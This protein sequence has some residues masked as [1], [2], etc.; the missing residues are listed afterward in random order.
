MNRVYG[1]IRTVSLPAEPVSQSAGYRSARHAGGSVAG[2]PRTHRRSVYDSRNLS[3]APA[4]SLRDRLRRPLQNPVCR[5]VRQLSGSGEGPRQGRALS[6]R[7]RDLGDG[8]QDQQLTATVTATAAATIC[9]QRPATAH[10]ARSVRANWDMSGLKSRRSVPLLCC[11]RRGL[12]LKDGPGSA[13]AA[14]VSVWL[15][16]GFI[17]SPSAR[18]GPSRLGPAG[19]G[20]SDGGVLHLHPRGQAR[21]PEGGRRREDEPPGEGWRVRANTGDDEH[22]GDEHLETGP[23][24]GSAPVPPCVWPR[25]PAFDPLRP[26]RTRQDLPCTSAGA[27]LTP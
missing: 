13:R 17:L 4:A 2:L 10:N 14:T 25:R 7:R 20:R 26:T 23:R 19:E 12:R 21:Y 5:Q 1:R 15:R 18:T 27:P 9:H 22:Q 16:W 3:R 24:G 11:L 8:D 6:Q